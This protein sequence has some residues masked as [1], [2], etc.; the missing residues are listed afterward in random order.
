[1][2]ARWWTTREDDQVRL[3]YPQMDAPWMAKKLGRTS[4]SIHRRAARIGVRAGYPVFSAQ[5]RARARV[6]RTK[7]PP[8]QR[9]EDKYIPVTETGC[10][11]W[12]ASTNKQG[13]PQF[14]EE[15]ETFGAAQWIYH[16]VNGYVAGRKWHTCGER[17][18]V[19]P[20]HMQIKTRGC[21]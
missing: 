5:A 16:Q 18:C 15:G 6:R 7:Y 13:F 10:W 19:N 3:Y 9:F 14:R 4:A 2:D 11:I 21:V 1:M 20:A 12:L 8:L 17:L